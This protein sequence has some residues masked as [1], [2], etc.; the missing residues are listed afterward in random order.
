[1]L[2]RTPGAGVR[3]YSQEERERERE[4]FEYVVNDIV[5]SYIYIYIFQFQSLSLLSYLEV[6]RLSGVLERTRYVII[7][8]S[9]L[10]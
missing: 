2:K 9:K 6:E 5:C 1:M 8:N 3:Y 4:R 10:G 7:F